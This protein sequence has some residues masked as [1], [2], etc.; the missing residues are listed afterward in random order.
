MNYT[1][2]NSC[3]DRGTFHIRRYGTVRS[4]SRSVGNKSSPRAKESHSAWQSGFR[5]SEDSKP[6]L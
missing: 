3:N 6:T 1:K 5:V 2:V 4:P